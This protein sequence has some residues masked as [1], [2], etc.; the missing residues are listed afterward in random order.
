MKLASFLHILHTTSGP[1]GLLPFSLLR[2][3]TTAAE[4]AVF[5]ILVIEFRALATTSLNP[6]SEPRDPDL[7]G[8]VR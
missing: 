4:T 7:E 5:S 2:S 1:N 3:S 8:T 6:S